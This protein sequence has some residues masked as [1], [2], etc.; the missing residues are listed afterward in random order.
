MGD[1]V[2]IDPSMIEDYGRNTCTWM[3]LIEGG[4][5]SFMKSIVEHN[6]NISSQLVDSWTNRRVTITHISFYVNEKVITTTID[7]STYKQKWKKVI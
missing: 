1:I 5:V 7:L 6:D 2:H 3:D 4:L